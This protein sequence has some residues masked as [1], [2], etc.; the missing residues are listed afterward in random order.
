MSSGNRCK[1]YISAK[2]RGQ[3][4]CSSNYAILYSLCLGNVS[5]SIIKPV[6]LLDYTTVALQSKMALPTETTT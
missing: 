2:N 6:T 1:L 3:N 5:N 4:F